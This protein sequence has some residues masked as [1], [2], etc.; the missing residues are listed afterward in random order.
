[1][2]HS[3]QTKKDIA[4]YMREHGLSY[5]KMGKKLKVSAQVLHNFINTNQQNVGIK[6]MDAFHDIQL[7]EWDD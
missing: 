3:K 2:K 1:M 4:S 6:I 5:V 7:D